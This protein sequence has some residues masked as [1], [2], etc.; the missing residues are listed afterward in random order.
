MPEANFDPY[1]ERYKHMA[2]QEQP[3]F[4]E[5]AVEGL[6]HGS[7]VLREQ[8]DVIR[9]AKN[10]ERFDNALVM[11]A[12]SAALVSAGI[13][14]YTSR[15]AG[16]SGEDYLYITGLTVATPLALARYGKRCLDYFMYV[17]PA[18][19]NAK[20]VESWHRQARQRAIELGSMTPDDENI[21]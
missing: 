6:E 2:A 3:Y 4:I 7:R 21:A 12:G 19:K 16:A 17:R 9:N 20:K 11:A 5:A 18:K 1:M 13:I 14:L 15:M 10:A 8:V